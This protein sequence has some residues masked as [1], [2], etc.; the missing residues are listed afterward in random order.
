MSYRLIDHTADLGLHVFGADPQTLFENAA[1]ALFDQITD[2]QKVK[3]IH[4]KKLTVQ[5]ID[6][7]DL[8]VCWLRELLFLWEARA[9]LVKKAKIFSISAQHV[10]AILSAD[11]F[12]PGRH[13]IFKEI[14]AVTYHQIQAH[15]GPQ[16]WEAKIIFDI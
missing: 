6:W 16:G 5:G 10:S 3:G 8:M 14:K 9:L 12:I 11:S 13:E 1:L 4:E 15:Q 7:P 2:L